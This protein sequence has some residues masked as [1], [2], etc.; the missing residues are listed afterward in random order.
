MFSSYSSYFN[1][2]LHQDSPE[3]SLCHAAS[4]VAEVLAWGRPHLLL[5]SGGI[6]KIIV[7]S[8]LVWGGRK[9]L[10]PMFFKGPQVCGSRAMQAALLWGRSE[11]E[12]GAVLSA[13]QKSPF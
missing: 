11:L 12:A 7:C 2:F 3:K 4:I 10:F 1:I 8:F 9:K 6:G 13:E 5:C